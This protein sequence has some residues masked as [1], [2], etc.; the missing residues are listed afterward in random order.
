MIVS[1]AISNYLSFDCNEDMKP[2]IDMKPARPRNKMDHILDAGVLKSAVLFGGNGSGKS[3]IIKGLRFLKKMVTTGWSPYPKDGFYCKNDPANKERP[4][5]FRIEFLK[6]HDPE[7]LS[8]AVDWFMHRGGRA[9]DD[10]QLDA[11]ETPTHYVYEIELQYV[12]DCLPYNIALEKIST[13]DYG[14]EVERI[15]YDTTLSVDTFT[16]ED[17]STFAQ[18]HSLRREIIAFES[19]IS[20]LEKKKMLINNKQREC[21]RKKSEIEALDEDVER[22]I[23]NDSEKQDCDRSSLALK[24]KAITRQLR[25]LRYLEQILT[26]EIFE[27]DYNIHRC[28]RICE[29]TTEKIVNI[30]K[31]TNKSNGPDD[32]IKCLLDVY[33]SRRASEYSSF[34]SIYQ[35]T[36]P[37]VSREKE[38]NKPSEW[39]ENCIKNDVYEWFS[40]TLVLVDI[41]DRVLPIGGFDCLERINGLLPLFD[42]KIKGLTYKEIKNDDDI[43]EIVRRID[44]NTLLSLFNCVKAIEGFGSSLTKIVAGGND[45]YE[46]NYEESR[47]RIKKLMSVHKDGSVHEMIEESDGT[48]R[49]IELASVLVDP[50]HEKVYLIDELD[51]KLHPLI[52]MNFVSSFYQMRSS[53]IQLILT[54]HETRLATTDTFRL[55]E[56]NLVDRDEHGTRVT[57]VKDAVKDYSKPLDE[58]YLEGLLMG[59]IPRIEPSSQ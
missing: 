40:D 3:N 42:A 59:G 1:L 24:K 25:E 17:L 53:K 58:M 21:L 38:Y 18:I 13:V 32:K 27:V 8:D 41:K 56:I 10:V 12:S 48:R 34:Q 16:N 36:S 46:L 44:R 49:L 19:Q 6:Q 51:R 22:S 28:R 31:K 52:T 45:L 43:G 54:T 7:D 30:E 11:C 15:R 33:S 47:F 29:E 55:D 23:R 35:K 4:I 57:R 39:I 26:N 5:R 50:D 9:L 37:K 14:R 2:C 20:E